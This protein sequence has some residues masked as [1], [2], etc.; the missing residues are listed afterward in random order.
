MNKYQ[1]ILDKIGLEMFKESLE[2]KYYLLGL[3]QGLYFASMIV[4][5]FCT[6][7][8]SKDNLL[9]AIDDI[10]TSNW[11]INSYFNKFREYCNIKQ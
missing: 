2:Y 1:E 3:T 8:K 11:Y 10:V 6:D 7:R 4:N 5:E 9:S